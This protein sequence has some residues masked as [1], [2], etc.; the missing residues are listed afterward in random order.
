[1]VMRSDPARPARKGSLRPLATSC[2][3]VR[4]HATSRVV[5]ALT[6]VAR[7]RGASS[8]AQAELRRRARR[9]R[10]SLSEHAAHVVLP[11]QSRVGTRI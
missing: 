6:E 1:M 5:Q 9:A 4:P 2:S 3:L 8:R 11:Q 10:P 7:V